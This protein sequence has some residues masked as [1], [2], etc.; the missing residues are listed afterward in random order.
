[1]ATKADWTLADM[2]EELEEVVTS[3][4]SKVPGLN[5][6]KETEIAKKLHKVITGVSS[7]MGK[8][9]TLVT[10]EGM[11]RTQKLQAAVSASTTVEEINMLI[12][13]FS[14]TTLMHKV[15]RYRHNNGIKLPDTP[16][17]T[18]AIIQSEGRNFLTST[19]KQKMQ[20]SSQRSMRK[21]LRRR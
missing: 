10:L 5:N 6:N 12:Q 2:N 17:A 15:L 4:M 16:E 8:D 18:Q 3:W 7:V 1:M 14:T 9:A 21:T 19:Q 13:Q 11:N 20:R